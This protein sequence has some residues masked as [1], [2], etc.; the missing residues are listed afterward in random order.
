VDRQRRAADRPSG[1][2]A[3]TTEIAT[4][5]NTL[6]TKRLAR[7]TL[8]GRFLQNIITPAA[9]CSAG[10]SG[11]PPGLDGI[12]EV[13]VESSVSSA[14]NNRPPPRF[15]QPRAARTRSTAPSS[16]RVEIAGLV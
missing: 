13:R 3:A 10:A 1:E 2:I 11:R 6:E 16:T 9:P 12:A 7:L 8:N 14:K 4:L 15:C 5:A